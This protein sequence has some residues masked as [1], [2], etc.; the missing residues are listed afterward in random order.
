M[1]S[2]S[3][4]YSLIKCFFFF[5]LVAS[6]SVFYYSIPCSSEQEHRLWKLLPGLVG[7]CWRPPRWAVLQERR[8]HLHPQQ[9]KTGSMARKHPDSPHLSRRTWSKTE[10]IFKCLLPC[11]LRRQQENMNLQKKKKHCWINMLWH[12]DNAYM[13][14][15]QKDSFGVSCAG[16]RGFWVWKLN[17]P[18]LCARW[19]D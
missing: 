8:H 18:S 16:Q 14:Q 6:D 3:I 4:L 2:Q 1:L 9:G 17:T 11:P 12:L 10:I 13:S 7:L 19:W 5:F 15:M